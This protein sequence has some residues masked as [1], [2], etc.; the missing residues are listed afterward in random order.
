MAKTCHSSGV[1]ANSIYRLYPLVIVFVKDKKFFC[2]SSPEDDNQ[3]TIKYTQGE[4]ETG[5][6]SSPL[7][8]Q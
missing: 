5:R 7:G 1:S 4:V 6:V 3:P 2:E 8:E